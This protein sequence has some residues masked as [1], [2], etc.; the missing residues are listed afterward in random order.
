MRKHPR[1]GFTLF[2]LLLVLAILAILLGLLLPVVQKVREAAARTQ[3]ANN[4]KQ[5]GLANFIY[6][7]SSIR[8]RVGALEVVLL[9]KPGE[10]LLGQVLGVIGLMALPSH[11]GVL[12]PSA[13]HAASRSTATPAAVAPRACSCVRSLPA[14]AASAAVRRTSRPPSL[15]LSRCAAALPT[16]CLR[17]PS[18]VLVRSPDPSSPTPSPP[19]GA[20]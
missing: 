13:R 20:R 18:A 1:H 6:A 4:L 12:L 7:D 3:S 10:K 14:L 19:A 5:I 16:T 15:A 8:S 17:A 9:Q 11:K 2:Q